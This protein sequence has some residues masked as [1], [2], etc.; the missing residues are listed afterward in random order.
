MLRKLSKKI[1]FKKRKSPQ[2]T[3]DCDGSLK[4]TSNSQHLLRQPYEET[5]GKFRNFFPDHLRS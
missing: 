4:Y 5:K 3:N 1:T 2:S